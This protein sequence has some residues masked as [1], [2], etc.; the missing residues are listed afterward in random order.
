MIGQG[1]GPQ[2]RRALVVGGLALV[3]GLGRNL[4]GGGQRT[5]LGFAE[6][7]TARLGQIVEGQVAGGVAGGADF[8]IDLIAALQCAAIIG[9]EGAFE[10]EL[11][12]LGMQP[13]GVDGFG[14]EDRGG[15]QKPQSD[16]K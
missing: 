4:G 9:A 7:R 12:R 11:H 6:F 5:G 1:S 3:V 13:L 14:S 8:L 10:F 2:Q 16:A 15:S